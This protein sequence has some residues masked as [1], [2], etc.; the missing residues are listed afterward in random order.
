MYPQTKEKNRA[1]RFDNRTF[2]ASGLQKVFWYFSDMTKT[3][4]NKEKNKQFVSYRKPR[5]LRKKSDKRN[6]K[7]A[8]VVIL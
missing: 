2:P 3:L 5:V 7:P 4:F 8:R 1:S 6:D